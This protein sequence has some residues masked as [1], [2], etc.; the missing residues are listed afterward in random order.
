MADL[1]DWTRVTPV[2]VMKAH[3]ELA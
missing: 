2:N 1:D 3:G